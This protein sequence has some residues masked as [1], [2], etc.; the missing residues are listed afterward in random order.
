MGSKYARWVFTDNDGPEPLPAAA[1]N[2]TPVPGSS[3]PVGA[4]PRAPRFSQAGSRGPHFRVGPTIIRKG[5]R[6]GSVDSLHL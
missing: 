5:Q 1:W 4:V 3:K 2:V 6:F